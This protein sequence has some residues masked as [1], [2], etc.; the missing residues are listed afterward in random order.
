M[1][2]LSKN[3]QLL[4]SQSSTAIPIPKI[5][6]GSS[7]HRSEIRHDSPSNKPVA[8]SQ[9]KFNTSDARI[10][11][12]AASTGADIEQIIEE[13]ENKREMGEKVEVIENMEE[14][15]REAYI[16][17]EEKALDESIQDEER[18][19]AES[20]LPV[21]DKVLNNES[22]APLSLY[23]FYAYLREVWQAEDNLN[24]WLD[25]ITH[26]KAFKRWVE[27]EKKKKSDPTSSNLTSRRSPPSSPLYRESY[28]G[29]PSVVSEDSAS[30]AIVSV[31][32]DEDQSV[33]HSDRLSGVSSERSTEL[34][35]TEDSLKKSAKEVYRKY[36]SL[37][38]FPEEN[39]KT[40]HDLIER[41]GRYNPVVFATS[42]AYVYHIMSVVYFPKF[43]QSAVETN[44]TAIHA[45]IALPLGIVA[46]TGGI[47][48]ILFYIFQGSESRSVRLWGFIPIWCGWM[49]LQIAATRFAPPLVLLKLSEHK[50]FR[51]HRIKEKGI[52]KAHRKKA[53]QLLVCDTLVA[54][55]N[56]ALLMAIPPMALYEQTKQ[57]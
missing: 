11:T 1:S 36:A 5:A 46:L 51:F 15:V 55:F 56:I 24:A 31:T 57:S 38:I 53:M 25:I 32:T 16:R 43:I 37:N 14:N 6:L 41:Q 7:T 47:S 20:E 35:V 10:F 26:E 23:N 39:K 44:L 12:Q 45:I 22:G 8:I 34:R 29:A 40:M 18:R 33:I 49:L 9:F 3:E 13:E 30:H 54:I 50:L 42:K 27:T 52:L 4:L 17:D 48:L 2:Q 28:S 21:L 19:R